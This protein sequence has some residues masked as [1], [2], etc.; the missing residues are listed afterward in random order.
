MPRGKWHPLFHTISM[1][2][3]PLIYSAYV[4]VAQG[5]APRR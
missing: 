1:I 5:A 3:F 4:G 2:A